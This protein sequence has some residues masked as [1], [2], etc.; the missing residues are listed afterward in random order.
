MEGLEQC[1]GDVAEGGM[2]G[3]LVGI[4]GEVDGLE[5]P[6]C[7]DERWFVIEMLVGGLTRFSLSVSLFG[8]ARTLRDKE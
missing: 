3:R 6:R 8:V 5:W 1:G 7:V 2:D 4:I